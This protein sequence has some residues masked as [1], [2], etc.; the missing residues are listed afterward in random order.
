MNLDCQH[1][2]FQLQSPEQPSSPSRWLPCTSCST[3]VRPLTP[4]HAPT[5]G[6]E[7]AW[8]P[9]VAYLGGGTR[10]QRHDFS[11]ANAPNSYMQAERRSWHALRCAL[12][13]PAPN[14][15]RRLHILAN[16]GT[17]VVARP[18]NQP[19]LRFPMCI[20]SGRVPH[21]HALSFAMNEGLDSCGEEY[22][23]R[24]NM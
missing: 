17:V 8:D 6:Q 15:P 23:L 14:L 1:E 19:R 11:Q 4:V 2:A 9:L 7:S 10:T 22:L 13:R 16:L 18:L 20:G 3:P 12:H 5:L 21:K 24:S